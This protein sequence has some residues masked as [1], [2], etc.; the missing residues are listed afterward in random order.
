MKLLVNFMFFVVELLN[1]GL[2]G[3]VRTALKRWV[4]V[5]RLDIKLMCFTKNAS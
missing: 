2:R 1:S 4:L 5:E 3:I